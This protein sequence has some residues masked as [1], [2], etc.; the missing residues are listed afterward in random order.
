VN[1]IETLICLHSRPNVVPNKGS[2]FIRFGTRQQFDEL[3]E[4]LVA[5][6]NI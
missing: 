5:Q 3:I 1:E 4:G 6:L 2:Q